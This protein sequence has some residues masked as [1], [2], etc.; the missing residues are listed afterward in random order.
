MIFQ[1]TLYLSLFI[2]GIGIVY[3]VYTWLHY[4]IGEGA[5]NISTAERFLSALKGTFRTIFSGKIFRLLQIFLLD[6]ILQRR[7]LKEDF[8]RWLMHMCIF[9]GFMLLLL[10]HGLEKFTTAAL[11]PDYSP[12]LFPFSFLRNVFFALV[13]AGLVLAVYRRVFMKIPHLVTTRVDSYAIVILAV[14]MLSGLLLEGMKIVSH[15]RFQA[16]VEDYA[17]TGDES[18]LK[19]L[20]SYWV[21]DFGVVSPGLKGPFEQSVLDRG[22]EIHESSCQACHS[23]PQWAFVS[24]GTSRI[25]RPVAGLLDKGDVQTFFWYLHFLACFIGLAYLPFSKMFHILA[26]PLS[27]LVNGVMEGEKSDPA[28]LASKRALELDACTRCKTCSLWCS[29]AAPLE[30]VANANILPSERILS[31]KT[32]A[33]GKK[34]SEEQIGEIWKGTYRC[35]LCGRCKEVC[36]AGIGLKDLWMSMRE[37]LFRAGHHPPILSIVQEAIH[38]QHNPMD[39]DN[40]ER[41]MWVEFMDDPPDDNFQK[42][43]A[44]VVYFV[45]CVSSFSPAVQMIPE[46]FCR[47]LT[48]AGVDFTIMGEK[49]H[50]CGFPMLLAGIHDGVEELKRHN[51][52]AVRERGADTV[53]FSCPSCYHTWAHDYGED[54]GDIKLFHATQYLEKMIREGRL[55][56][57]KEVPEIVTYH[58][59]CDLGRNSG[60][61]LAPRR[62]ITSIPGVQFVEL[63]ENGRKALCCGGGGDVEMYDDGLTAQVARKKAEQVQ[64]TGAT[65]CVTACQQCVRTMTKGLRGIGSKAEALDILQLVWRSLS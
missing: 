5:K 62:V 44:K 24:Y 61:Y 29:V 10:M 49:E 34:V 46:I 32:L 14:I 39:Y 47:I 15:S 12:T 9:S 50:C 7:I 4:S 16:M 48:K 38:N 18:D 35:T 37:D 22:K 60:E 21:E 54:V 8:L 31:L 57:T 2:F 25:L 55:N 26:S 42:E 64:A 20:E 45:G 19:A 59:P 56:L 51:I 6:V 33:A 17:D 1:V 11:F 40:E 3:R 30:T 52:A 23:K 41:S 58:D 63:S 27:L 65:L 28:N 53:V 43:E 13:I 36:P